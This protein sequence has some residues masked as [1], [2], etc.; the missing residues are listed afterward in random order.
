MHYRVGSIFWLIFGVYVAI[1]GY[2]L[3]LGNFRQ[4][5]PGFIFFLASLLLAILSAI[6]LGRTFIGRHKTT[7]GNEEKP[8]WA[9]FRWPKILAV[10]TGL[11]IYNYAF[12][13]LGFLPSTFLLMI[14]LFKVVE[15]MKWWFSILGSLITILVTFGIFSLWLNVPFPQ[16]VLGF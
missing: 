7:V 8:I 11:C 13:F 9:G 15:P 12:P 3:G 14:F 16:G 2:K 6:D 1:I 10:L 4:P 5:G